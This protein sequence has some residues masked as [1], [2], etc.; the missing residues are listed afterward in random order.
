MHSHVQAIKFCSKTKF[1]SKDDAALRLLGFN[2]SSFTSELHSDGLKVFEAQ[3]LPTESPA[4]SYSREVM[5]SIEKNSLPD[6]LPSEVAAHYLSQKANQGESPVYKPRQLLT[7][8][9]VE[10]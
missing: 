5:N 3:L 4:Y 7:V 10:Y 6:N 2:I 9:A 8:P 1:S